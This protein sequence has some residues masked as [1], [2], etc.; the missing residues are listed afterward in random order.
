MLKPNVNFN[1]E[2]QVVLSIRVIFHRDTI[3]TMLPAKCIQLYREF[4]TWCPRNPSGRATSSD[5]STEC[6]WSRIHAGRRCPTLGFSPV[7]W[8]LVIY[9]KHFVTHINEILSLISHPIIYDRPFNGWPPRRATVTVLR[10]YVATRYGVVTEYGYK[11]HFYTAFPKV[12]RKSH[13]GLL[14][15]PKLENGWTDLANFGLELFVEVQGRF[16]RIKIKIL[17][18]TLNK[19]QKTSQVLNQTVT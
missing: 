7:S 4:L 5:D 17:T 2:K 19:N 12:R 9:L 6:Y 16:K 3:A 13:V 11:E 8:A 15:S 1:K 18:I 14:I 10:C